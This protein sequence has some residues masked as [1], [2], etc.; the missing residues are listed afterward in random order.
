MR[1]SIAVCPLKPGRLDGYNSSLVSA[2]PSL[3]GSEWLDWDT[4]YNMEVVYRV[5]KNTSGG[6]LYSRDA[7]VM[8]SDAAEFA[9][10][11]SGQANS[12]GAAHAVIVADGY[13]STGIPAN[14]YFLVVV[15]GPAVAKLPDSAS[16]RMIFGVG[17]FIVAGSN[18]RVQ[19][20]DL[21]GATAPLA[22]Q[23]QNRI[24]AA[25]TSFAA[26]TNTGTAFPIRVFYP[27]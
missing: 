23:I 21:T 1:Q 27:W 13:P 4:T 25:L 12:D 26:S 15:E 22:A 5:V 9:K 14:E 7:V 6:A 3:L 19:V 17:S 20:Q 18:G 24:G 16:N 2:N 10:C 8:D 11:V